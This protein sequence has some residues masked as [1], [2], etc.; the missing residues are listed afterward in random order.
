LAFA[1]NL[2]KYSGADAPAEGCVAQ[3]GWKMA[4]PLLEIEYC[5]S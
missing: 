4:K 3:G 1:W 2:L 5:T